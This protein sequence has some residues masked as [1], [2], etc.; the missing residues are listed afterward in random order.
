[1]LII[2]VFCQRHAT[3]VH[4]ISWN[5]PGILFSFNKST[6]EKRGAMWMYTDVII[7]RRWMMIML[8]GKDDFLP[9]HYLSAEEKKG[10]LILLQSSTLFTMLH[11]ST[12][13]SFLLQ[14]TCSFVVLVT[15]LWYTPFR[16]FILFF[17]LL[18]IVC[19]FCVIPGM[20]WLHLETI[21]FWL[22]KWSDQG[23]M[24]QWGS[25]LSW[26]III[27]RDECRG[28]RRCALYIRCGIIFV[29]AVFIRWKCRAKPRFRSLLSP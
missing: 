22:I 2:H 29:P 7:V 1:M 14:W 5:I 24:M 21:L 10:R 20:T 6:D 19:P 3:I 27:S 18:L 16:F 26:F 15:L 25:H 12:K 28:G 9:R 4:Y 8:A 13:K 17:S 11:A 23:R